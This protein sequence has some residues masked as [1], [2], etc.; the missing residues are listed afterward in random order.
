MVISFQSLKYLKN[1]KSELKYKRNRRRPVI[2]SFK[3]I[4][5]KKAIIIPYFKKE[6]YYYSVFL[7]LES[8]GWVSFKQTWRT[9]LS[10]SSHWT[11]PYSHIDVSVNIDMYVYSQRWF[12][13]SKIWFKGQKA[14]FQVILQARMTMPDSQRYPWSL[15]WLK[16]WKIL[17]FF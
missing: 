13:L 7:Y 11:H 2:K 9:I 6:S 8:R 5:K 16:L 3:N 14:K 17:S 1:M 15:I 4:L 12:Q 10:C